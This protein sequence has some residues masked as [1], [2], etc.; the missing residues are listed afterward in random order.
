MD[1]KILTCADLGTVRLFQHGAA[2]QESSWTQPQ[3][4]VSFARAVGGGNP[5][6]HPTGDVLAAAAPPQ[7]RKVF[8]LCVSGTSRWSPAAPACSAP[9]QRISALPIKA[10]LCVPVPPVGDEQML[11]SSEVGS[12]SV[13]ALHPGL[14][15]LSCGA[16]LCWLGPVVRKSQLRDAA[17]L[18]PFGVKHWCMLWCA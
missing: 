7:H 5:L 16:G 18:N 1:V 11:L 12:S 15:H 6:L 3:C 17:A 8:P 2:L 13:L 4:L 9:A 10:A 14:G